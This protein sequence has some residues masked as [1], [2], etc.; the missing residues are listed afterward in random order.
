MRV[1]VHIERLVVDGRDFGER[2][3]AHQDEAFRAALR[4]ELATL[5][6]AARAAGPWVPRTARSVVVPLSRPEGPGGAEVFGRA[7]ARSLHAVLAPGA[8]RGRA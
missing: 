1:V 7:V 3:P 8:G 2:L 4:G 6:A 5:F